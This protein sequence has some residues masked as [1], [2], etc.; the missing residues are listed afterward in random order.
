MARSVV[1][2]NL[3]SDKGE[4]QVGNKNDYLTLEESAQMLDRSVSFLKTFISQ[5][6]LSAKL[7]GGQW[8]ISVRDL[9]K[10]KKSPPPE[11]EKIIQDFLSTPS[12]QRPRR[13]PKP[14]T[15]S[16]VRR[17][18]SN[19]RD[20]AG[21]GEEL[22]I[23]DAKVRYLTVNIE[24]RL[25]LVN[26]G[27]AIWNK[28]RCDT[29]GLHKARRANLPNKILELL[30]DLRGTK[31][32]YILLRETDRYKRLLGTL[33]EWDSVRI[34]KNIEKALQK[35]RQQKESSVPQA[36]PVGGI[37]GYYTGRS[38]AKKRFWFNEED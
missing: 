16:I 32:R 3:G 13:N 18:T 33:P 37:D 22:E 27:R 20:T 15:G 29:Y 14:T 6:K 10:L 21:K 4:H 25:S 26:G 31:Q 38:I 5:G 23:L 2:V 17:V 34:A 30:E 8:L 24:A 35:K 36:K 12:P 7:A 19:T 28:I 1:E 9:D 11:P